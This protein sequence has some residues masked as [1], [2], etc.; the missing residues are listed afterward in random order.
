MGIG[1]KVAS[2]LVVGLVAAGVGHEAIKAIGAKDSSSSPAP[3]ALNQGDSLF[4]SVSLLTGGASSIGNVLARS[5][6]NP[7]RPGDRSHGSKT[8]HWE[9]GAANGGSGGSESAAGAPPT[10]QVEGV[11]QQVVDAVPKPPVQLPQLP[12][13]PPPPVQLPPPPPLLPPPP[14]VPELPQIP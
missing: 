3:A 11:V 4:S 14:R 2:V 10:H 8:G 6:S 7:R 1:A 13:L 12:Q 9:A 5:A